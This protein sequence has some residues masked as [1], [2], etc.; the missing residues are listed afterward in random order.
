LARKW[1]EFEKQYGLDL[2]INIFANEDEETK[3][4]NADLRE[5]KQQRDRGQEKEAIA[6]IKK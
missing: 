1:V 3:K 2:A 4:L 6:P 5:K